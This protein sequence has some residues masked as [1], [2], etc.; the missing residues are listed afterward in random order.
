M[1]NTVIPPLASLEQPE[2]LNTLLAKDQAL[3]DDCTP[4]RV[5]GSF[6]LAALFCLPGKFN[7]LFY[8][9]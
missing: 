4:C 5:T 9:C 3:A 1:G 6:N 7:A 8:A 2:K